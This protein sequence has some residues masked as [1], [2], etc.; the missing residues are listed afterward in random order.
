MKLTEL[1]M[2]YKKLTVHVTISKVNI[3]IIS[4]RSVSN[5]FQFIVSIDRTYKA[6]LK[7]F[8]KT[9]IAIFSF[10]ISTGPI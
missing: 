2:F 3:S 7:P 5:T 6:L 10:K 4:I 8:F 1:F 9:I